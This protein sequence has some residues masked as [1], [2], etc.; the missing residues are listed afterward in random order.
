MVSTGGAGWWQWVESRF[1]PLQQVSL[2]IRSPPTGKNDTEVCKK[3]STLCLKMMKWRSRAVF[4]VIHIKIKAKIVLKGRYE[5]MKSWIPPK[6]N[7]NFNILWMFSWYY[8]TDIVVGMLQ[9]RFNTNLLKTLLQ[10]SY[11]LIKKI[12]SW[13]LLSSDGNAQTLSS[14]FWWGRQN[15]LRSSMSNR[16]GV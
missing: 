11:F 15:E 3:T 5:G 4:R 13:V 1:S 6:P 12:C 10:T 16:K 9:L 2:Q 14:C 7:W 8:N